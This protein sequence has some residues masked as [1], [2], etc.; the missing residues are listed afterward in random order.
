MPIANTR[1][2][3]GKGVSPVRLPVFSTQAFPKSGVNLTTALAAMNLGAVPLAPAYPKHHC[4]PGGKLGI[5]VH[6]EP[7]S[8]ERALFPTKP[9]PIRNCPDGSQSVLIYVIPALEPTN[10]ML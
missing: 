5:A 9:L 7:K 3:L 10:T 4:T 2:M 8:D 6:V 1:L